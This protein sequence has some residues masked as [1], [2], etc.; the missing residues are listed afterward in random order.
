MRE[1][2][3]ELEQYFI[4]NAKQ[5]KEKYLHI[6][7]HKSKFKDSK[8]I[9]LMKISRLV[10]NMIGNY[11]FR[12]L[13][14]SDIE[15][16]KINLMINAS[17]LFPVATFTTFIKIF[18]DFTSVSESK[19]QDFYWDHCYIACLF[20]C[21]NSIHKSEIINKEDIITGFF[22]KTIKRGTKSNI[23]VLRSLFEL[24]DYIEGQ[25]KQFDFETSIGRWI[26][27]KLKNNYLSNEKLRQISGEYK[28]A[29]DIGTLIVNEFY[30]SWNK[31]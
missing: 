29:H 18:P 3:S 26:H 4:G 12:K 27:L 19:L 23:D 24:R 30:D 16:N 28:Y 6:E 2:W 22:I 20:V 13:H 1:S 17:S 11:K 8:Q 31:A 7:K 15:K 5:S 25:S 10:T 21:S 14:L 9:Y